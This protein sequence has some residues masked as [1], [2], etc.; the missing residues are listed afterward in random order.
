MQIFELNQRLHV[1]AS[2]VWPAFDYHMHRPQNV[3]GAR[4]NYSRIDGISQVWDADDASADDLLG[5]CAVNLL[6]LEP[7]C[8]HD[9]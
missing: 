6:E 3:I 4:V 1:E 8:L 5:R 2:S 7:G 9:R